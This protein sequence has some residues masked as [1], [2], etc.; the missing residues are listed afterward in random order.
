M[1]KE[2]IEKY[3][4]S[5][6]ERHK[7]PVYSVHLNDFTQT[8]V[9]GLPSNYT[10]KHTIG[11]LL[12]A[13][14][15]E[16]WKVEHVV[17]ANVE[18][19]IL[20]DNQLQFPSMVAHPPHYNSGKFEVIEIIE[21]QKLNFHTGNAVKYICRAG[22]KDPTKEI[23]DLEKAIWYLNRQIEVTKAAQVGREKVR[24]NEMNPRK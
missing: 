4:R 6:I 1:S 7:A 15:P 3:V 9:L 19:V 17:L 18:H 22:K 23:E 11:I 14:L 13:D 5:V 21:D 12:E 10:H 20:P 16:G 2:E 24:P 8:V